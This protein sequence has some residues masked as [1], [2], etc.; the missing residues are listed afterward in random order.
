[1]HIHSQSAAESPFADRAALSR[2]F[3]DMAAHIRVFEPEVE[4]GEFFPTFA[5]AN[6]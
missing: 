1:V 3:A 4:P 2:I 5:L 6:E